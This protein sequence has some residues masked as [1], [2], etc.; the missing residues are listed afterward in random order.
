MGRGVA[1]A[2]SPG[3]ADCAL[4][5]AG[6]SAKT[7]GLAPTALTLPQSKSDT[8]QIG[9]FTGLWCSCALHEGRMCAG[10]GD[11]VDRTCR[12]CAPVFAAVC[13]DLAFVASGSWGGWYGED[14]A[15]G[16]VCCT[17]VLGNRRPAAA[18]CPGTTER[19]S[20][21]WR[22]SRFPRHNDTYGTTA[23]RVVSLAGDSACLHQHRDQVYSQGDC[24]NALATANALVRT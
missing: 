11:C 16:M 23:P 8:P 20:A 13:I 17:I 18:L 2:L 4:R 1:A 14:C 15:L 6:V 21:A 19:H 3:R 10:R 24:R 9:I 7:V 12:W 5:Q 22:G